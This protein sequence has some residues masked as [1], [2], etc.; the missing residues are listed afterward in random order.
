MKHIF[1]P[2]KFN[3]F[4]K[5]PVNHDFLMTKYNHTNDAY[6]NDFNLNCVVRNLCIESWKKIPNVDVHIFTTQDIKDTFMGLLENDPFYQLTTNTPFDNPIEI[7]DIKDDIFSSINNYT[8]SPHK[9]CPFSTDIIRY[10]LAKLIPNAIYLDSDIYIYDYLKLLDAIQHSEKDT[11]LLFDSQCFYS[12]NNV[13]YNKMISEYDNFTHRYKNKLACDTT[14]LNCL[15][16]HNKNYFNDNIS[17]NDMFP[18]LYHFSRTKS[19]WFNCEMLIDVKYM[20]LKS[21]FIIIYVRNYYKNKN[22]IIDFISKC[23]LKYRNKQIIFYLQE[24]NVFNLKRITTELRNI[25]DKFNDNTHVYVIDDE[26]DVHRR[27]LK[28][29]VEIINMIKFKLINIYN[30]NIK[31]V[32]IYVYDISNE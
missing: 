24:D 28:S 31:D 18:H 22:K 5:I 27:Q 14:I 25:R 9:E 7:I 17:E 10:K 4:T 23:K 3:I 1:N 16:Q 6:T 26:E 8:M 15:K 29:N 20:D 2:T 21:D 32:C 11:S 30:L 13:F 19:Y 12:K